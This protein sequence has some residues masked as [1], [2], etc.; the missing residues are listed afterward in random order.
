MIVIVCGG[1]NFSDR[2]HLFKTLDTLHEVHGF[3]LIVHGAARGADRLAGEWATARGIACEPV[4]VDWQTYGLAAGPTRNRVMLRRFKPELVVA[5]DG[6][7]G[8]DHMMR[9]AE[10]AGVK[11]IQGK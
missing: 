6:G 11:V 4:A 9:I 10:K 1:R 8:T 7:T 3:T 2:E 5:F